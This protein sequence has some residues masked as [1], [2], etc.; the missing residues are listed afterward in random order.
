M[1]FVSFCVELRSTGRKTV[2]GIWRSW[3]DVVCDGALTAMPLV[4]VGP[5]A[6]PDGQHE[7]LD[8]ALFRSTHDPEVAVLTPRC[9]PRVG[10]EPV[11]LCPS[12]RPFDSPSDNADGVPAALLELG[13]Q[14]VFEPRVPVDAVPVQEEVRSNVNHGLHW[15]IGLNFEHDVLFPR[16]H[17]VGWSGVVL[18][19]LNSG[20][21]EELMSQV[22]TAADAASG[23]TVA[24]A[25]FIRV[26]LL[27]YPPIID[28]VSP[29]SVDVPTVASPAPAIETREEILRRE[30]DL[31]SAS[32]LDRQAVSC[33][34]CGGESPG[35]S[36]STLVPDSL[37]QTWPHLASIEALGKRFSRHQ[38][39]LAHFLGVSVRSVGSKVVTNALVQEVAVEE[40][41]VGSRPPEISLVDVPH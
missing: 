3:D 11:L 37:H 1:C 15:A 27:R 20:R 26:A 40:G 41:I 9:S 33:N 17:P 5:A 8:L 14:I 24:V 30:L 23:G 10:A 39:E 28:E 36:T 13:R 2:V 16:G 7:R 38:V 22:L 29:G 12:V 35:G 21:A 34:S 31:V 32:G 18:L 25:A 19:V 4:V 6:A